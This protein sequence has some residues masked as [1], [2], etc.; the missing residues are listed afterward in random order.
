MSK[1]P[2]TP[3]DSQAPAPDPGAHAWFL[4]LILV[5]LIGILML[6]DYQRRSRF[7]A[8]DT[9][10]PGRGKGDPQAS[11][12]ITQFL[13]LQSPESAEGQRVVLDF[14]A[15]R[16]ADLYF[17]TRYFPHDEE[18]LR[19]ATFVECSVQQNKYWVFTDLLLERQFQWVGL[20]HTETVL[21]SIAADAGL[22]PRALDHCLRSEEVMAN[23]AYDRSVAESYGVRTAPTYFLNRKK[24]V[25]VEPLRK[26]LAAW[27][28]HMTEYE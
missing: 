3:R 10:I 28:R 13:D 21:K 18:S 25:G 16:P 27:D 11:M 17:Q 9:L 23:I 15:K 19:A 12:K 1:R 2:H 26:A 20:P 4:V 24:V 14:L 6:A 5:L 8:L 7:P 22:D